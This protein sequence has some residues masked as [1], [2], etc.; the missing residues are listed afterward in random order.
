MRAEAIQCKLFVK[1]VVYLTQP[2]RIKRSSRLLVAPTVHAL[3]APHIAV[4]AVC[5][6]KEWAS[7]LLS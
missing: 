4:T 7:H 2:I 3:K 5:R 1:T 6:L